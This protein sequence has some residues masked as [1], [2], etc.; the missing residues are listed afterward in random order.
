MATINYYLD[1]ADKKGLSP[2]H[3]RINCNGKQIKVSTGSKTKLK[4][5][6]K[7]SQQI[8]KSAD[9]FMEVNHYLSYLKD[10]AD[11]L[12]N[13]TYKK[14]FTI[15]EIKNKLNDFIE[16]YKEDHSVN[17]VREQVELYGN[18]FTFIDLFAGAGGLSEGFITEGFDPQRSVINIGGD[19]S[20]EIA[21]NWKIAA[22]YDAAYN[23][24]AV[25]HS[26][27]LS[28]VHDF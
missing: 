25:E 6:D 20:A 21:E 23:M 27:H 15:K 17:I 1:K 16:N 28:A 13:R 10:R 8:K 9:N 26:G 2:I 4:D 3:L 22:G 18:P 7:D 11:E 24:D 14:A 19:I 12:L 5:F